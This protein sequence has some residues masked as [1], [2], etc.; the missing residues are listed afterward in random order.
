MKNNLKIDDLIIFNQNNILN[1]G[2]V[3]DDILNIII[4]KHVRIELLDKNIIWC[5]KKQVRT[6]VKSKLI[7]TLFE[8]L[9]YRTIKNGF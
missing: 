9:Q 7:K 5:N 4:G 6:I 1:I 8:E 2:K 3:T